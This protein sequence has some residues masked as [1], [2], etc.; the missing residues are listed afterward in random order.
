MRRGKPG[1]PT[2]RI[3]S[4]T[5]SATSCSIRATGKTLLAAAK[6][7]HLGPTVFRSTDLGKNWKEAARPPAFAKAADG[8]EG[9]SVDHT[10]WLTPGRA[11]DRDVWYAGTSPQGLFRSADGGVTWEPFSIIND[12]P[13]FREWMGTAAGRHAGRAEAALDHRRPARRPALLH[14]DVGRR[15]ARVD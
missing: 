7:G 1:G 15:R 3:S 13:Q 9:R 14:R 10:F 5:T 6:T 11:Q 8:K 4:A 12:D 2:A